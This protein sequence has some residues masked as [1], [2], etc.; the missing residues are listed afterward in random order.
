[1]SLKPSYKIIHGFRPCLDGYRVI[2][3]R[4]S[5]EIGMFGHVKQR[6]DIMVDIPTDGEGI[7]MDAEP[8]P[9][10]EAVEKIQQYLEERDRRIG[11]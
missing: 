1:M 6:S 10:V 9:V 4:T 2:L 8:H 3:R 5:F 7:F 11:D